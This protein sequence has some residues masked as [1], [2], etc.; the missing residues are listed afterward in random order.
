MVRIVDMLI[1]ASITRI[2][3]IQSMPVKTKAAILKWEFVPPQSCSVHGLDHFSWHL[4]LRFCQCWLLQVI[5]MSKGLFTTHY[6]WEEQLFIWFGSFL[7]L[8]Q[9][10]SQAVGV[11]DL[12]LS[13]TGRYLLG[14]AIFN[15]NGQLGQI[16]WTGLMLD[17]LGK[18][19]LVPCCFR[20]NV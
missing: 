19:G 6:L 18:L 1:D 4:L 11:C 20:D 3:Q 9:T 10:I 17:Y 14:E 8:I 7:Q 13:A 15:S 16:V 12:N 5:S 2:E